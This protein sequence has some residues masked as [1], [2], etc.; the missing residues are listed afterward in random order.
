M[1]TEFQISGGS[2]ILSAQLTL[3]VSKDDYPD[4]HGQLIQAYEDEQQIEL[5]AAFL[6][7]AGIMNLTDPWKVMVTGM[8]KE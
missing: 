7:T 8:N 6:G 5:S 1:M 4:L 2:M 3:R